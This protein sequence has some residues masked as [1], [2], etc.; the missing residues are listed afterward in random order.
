VSVISFEDG[1]ELARIEVG[2]Y[3]QRMWAVAVE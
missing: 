1:R 2:D 3:P